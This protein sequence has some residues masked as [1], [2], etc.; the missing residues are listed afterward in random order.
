ML[1]HSYGGNTVLFHTA[2][3]ER[4][5]FAVSSGAACTYA[6]KR[7]TGTGIEMAEVIPGFAA[8]F[9]IHDLVGCT[10]PRRLLIVAATE[11]KYAKD[12]AS[13]WQRSLGEYI[14]AGAEKQLEYKCFEGGHALT[15]ERFDYIMNWIKRAAEV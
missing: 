13:I 9:D 7:E 5:K 3:D 11:D 2:L 14:N 15:R 10:A 12:A 1:G 4:I 6:H 8:R